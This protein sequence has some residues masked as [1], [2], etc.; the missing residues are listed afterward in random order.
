MIKAS[1]SCDLKDINTFEIFSVCKNK[2][3]EKIFSACLSAQ[4]VKIFYVNLKE[5]NQHLFLQ[6]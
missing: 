3:L 1:F 2:M 6:N 5:R 4:F